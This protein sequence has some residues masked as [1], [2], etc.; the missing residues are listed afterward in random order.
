MR[1]GMKQK[2]FS[3]IIKD[4]EQREFDF[5]GRRILLVEDNEMNRELVVDLMV[6]TGVKIE[7]ANDGEQGV[8]KFESSKV[9]YYDL[10]LMDIQMPRMNG[11]VATQKIRSLLRIDAKTVPILAVTAD[12]LAEDVAMAFAVGMN[13]HY[14]K[15]FDFT[16]ICSEIDNYFKKKKFIYVFK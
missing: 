8:E 5:T 14:A 3:N 1:D 15:P 13:A 9:G 2:E 6:N 10:I 7:C 4:R 11:Y 16:T 12:V